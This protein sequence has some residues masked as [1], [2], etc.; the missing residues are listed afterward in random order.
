MFNFISA[1]LPRKPMCGATFTDRNGII[2]NPNYPI[3]ESPLD[4]KATIRAN[5]GQIIK[6]YILGMSLNKE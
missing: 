1:E 6:A 2:S 5:P 4:C 3:Y